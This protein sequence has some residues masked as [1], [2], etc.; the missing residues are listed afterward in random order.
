MK[1]SSVWSSIKEWPHLGWLTIESGIHPEMES[2]S[3]VDKCFF[4]TLSY[5]FETSSC[6]R[7]LLGRGWVK[8]PRHPLLLDRE[9]GSIEWKMYVHACA[10]VCVCACVW[11]KGNSCISSSSRYSETNR[12]RDDLVHQQSWSCPCGLFS[13]LFRKVPPLSPPQMPHMSPL[14]PALMPWNLQLGNYPSGHGC[15]S[16]S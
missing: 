16:P 5:S 13:D 15:K 7:L 12:V 6:W 11:D 14:G 4:W 10:F 2:F 8:V 3:N 1:A 9:E